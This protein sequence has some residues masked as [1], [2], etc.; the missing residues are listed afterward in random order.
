[1]LSIESTVI[2]IEITFHGT[3]FALQQKMMARSWPHEKNTQA[4]HY[5]ASIRDGDNTPKIPQTGF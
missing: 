3:F 4:L 2:L 1:M 5:R